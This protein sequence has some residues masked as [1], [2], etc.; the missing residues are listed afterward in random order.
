MIRQ[1]ITAILTSLLCLLNASAQATPHPELKAFPIAES[2]MQRWVINLPEKANEDDW[3]V[4]LS[5]GTTLN[6]DGVN[7]VWLINS[8]EQQDLTGWGYTYYRIQGPAQAAST[9]MAAIPGRPETPHW[10]ATQPIQI[11]YNS[12]L[13]IVVYAPTEFQVRY[14][15]WSNAG[16]WQTAITE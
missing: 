11:R 7:H 4:E 9:L 8:L 14:R 16:D 6:T 5:A 15:L 12:R 2:G 3:K 10:V 13:P 1:R